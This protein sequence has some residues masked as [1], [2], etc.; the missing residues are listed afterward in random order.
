MENDDVY[1][2]QQE[3]VNIVK[4]MCNKTICS[5]V[6][7][8]YQTGWFKVAVGVRHGCLLSLTLFNLFLDFAK[9][10]VRCLQEQVT[11]DDNLSMSLKYAV[12]TTLMTPTFEHL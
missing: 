5:V 8:E 11:F 3:I 6:I 9:Q 10:K 12:D 7:D 2:Y 1:W 4:N